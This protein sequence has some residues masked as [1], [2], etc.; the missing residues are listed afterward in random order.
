MKSTQP[1]TTPAEGMTGLVLP[2]GWTVVRRIPKDPKHTGGY[3]SVGYDVEGPNGE[4]AFLKALDIQKVISTPGA[5]MATRTRDLTASFVYERNLMRKC[6]DA[7]LRRVIRLLADGE[8]SIQNMGVPYLI[9]ERAS[10][11]VRTEANDLN[12][13]DFAWTLRTMH[14]VATGVN[15]L[16][17][18]SIAHQDLKPS[19]VLITDD[20]LR[21]LGDLGRSATAECELEHMDNYCPGDINYW[22][23]EA[24]YRYRDPEW[25]NHRFGSDFYQTGNLFVYM[26]T[27]LQMTGI[28]VQSLE[29][30]FKPER[31]S[32][33]YRQVCPYLNEAHTRC[34]EYVAQYV[35]EMTIKNEVV[36]LISVLCHPVLEQRGDQS[37]RVLNGNP[38]LL[39][40]VISKFNRFATGCEYNLFGL[41]KA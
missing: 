23:P 39:D 22:P 6:R 29:A 36:N 9:F 18:Q 27:G 8:E 35:P 34:L 15:Q 14:H 31:W 32:G 19:N 13:F 1:I 20:G 37:R 16:H 30:K 11:D 3:F 21:K 28:L 17:S 12:R 10:S 33:T 24:L 38:F 2:G 40:R 41:L 4:V 25:I 7:G 26:L 5:D